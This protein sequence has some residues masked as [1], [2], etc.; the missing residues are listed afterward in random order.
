MNMNFKCK[1]P[2]PAEVKREFPVSE[3]LEKVIAA[4]NVQIADII[5]SKDDRLLLIIGPCSAD[6]EDS[7]MD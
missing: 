1:L 4:R 5:S 2:I 3:E 6:H 7:V